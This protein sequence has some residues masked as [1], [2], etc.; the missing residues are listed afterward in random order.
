[1]GGRP[2]EGA[3]GPCERLH[4]TAAGVLRKQRRHAHP[5]LGGVCEG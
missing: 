1:M 4:A 3:Q 2:E 5:L